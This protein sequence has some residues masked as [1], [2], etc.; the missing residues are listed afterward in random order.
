M[1]IHGFVFER[2]PARGEKQNAFNRRWSAAIG[3][4]GVLLS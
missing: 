4:S 1:R 3:R 2:F